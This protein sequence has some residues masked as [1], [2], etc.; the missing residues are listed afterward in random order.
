VI[1]EVPALD[2]STFSVCAATAMLLLPALTLPEPEVLLVGVV[3]EGKEVAEEAAVEAVP[4]PP[5]QAARA[6]APIRTTI[7]RR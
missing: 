2:T 5:P 3:A 4:D 7:G 6:S 1:G